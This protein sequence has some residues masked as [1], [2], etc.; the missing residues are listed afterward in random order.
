MV[1]W[2]KK[3]VSTFNSVHKVAPTYYIDR[4]VI[5][6]CFA[7]VDSLGRDRGRRIGI[8]ESDMCCEKRRLPLLKVAGRVENSSESECRKR[9][10]EGRK[11]VGTWEGGKQGK[12]RQVMYTSCSHSGSVRG[13]RRRRRRRPREVTRTRRTDAQHT[14]RRHVRPSVRPRPSRGKKG[15]EGRGRGARGRGRERAPAPKAPLT[16]LHCTVP[17]WFRLAEVT[18]VDRS[19]RVVQ[20][21]TSV[22]I[23]EIGNE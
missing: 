12:R 14:M 10:A 6:Y 1:Q 17:P 21:Q 18:L 19:T 3:A 22:N 5:C 9:G 13:R 15:T 8:A 16:V 11:E 4:H 20:R 2:C 23:S 7:V